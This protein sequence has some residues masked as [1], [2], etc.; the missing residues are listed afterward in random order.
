MLLELFWKLHYTVSDCLANSSRHVHIHCCSQCP[1]WSKI[2]ILAKYF[3]STCF[4]CKSK[5]QKKKLIIVNICK[6]TF[7][8]SS[9]LFSIAQ[10]G[11]IVQCYFWSSKPKLSQSGSNFL[12]SCSCFRK[13]QE[14]CT[15]KMVI[16]IV[17]SHSERL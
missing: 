16:C 13:P 5:Y 4:L 10:L 12:W 14:E 1:F 15:H 8:T 3:D 9:F 2:H 17:L 7:L 6:S 11:G